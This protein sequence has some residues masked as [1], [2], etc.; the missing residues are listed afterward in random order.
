MVSS[1]L[2]TILET[3]AVITTILQYLSGVIVCRKYINKKSTGDSSGF[4]FICGFLSCSLW[5]R[6]GTLTEETIVVTVNI[7]GLA[8]MFLYSA[9]YYVFTV[10]KRSYVRQFALA[11][12][13]LITI[14]TYTKY[15]VSHEEAI[16]LMGYACCIVT[17]FFFAAPLIMLFHVVR[18]KNSE[19]L[20]F[21][22][23][24][25][26][27][28]VTVQWLIYGVIIK[29]AFIQIPNFLGCLLSLVQLSLFVCYPPKNYSGQGYKLV[30]Q[31]VI[32]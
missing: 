30:D 26:S 16:Q 6:Y 8:L 2:E 14:V 31:A 32:F 12:F 25:M 20:P 17:V 9:I 5:L 24:A 3:S 29:D 22:L 13:T 28:F 21:P 19:S 10:N 27:F 4:P 15:E 18:V 7:I 11:L 23:I 1:S